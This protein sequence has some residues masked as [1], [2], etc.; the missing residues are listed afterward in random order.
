MYIVNLALRSFTSKHLSLRQFRAFVLSS[1]PLCSIFI[2]LYSLAS[3]EI[4]SYPHCIVL[5]LY[6]IHLYSASRS[7]HQSEALPVRET[8]KEDTSLERMKRGTWLTSNCW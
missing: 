6:S 4:S 1:R 2:L 3:C 7:A 8:Q 5:C